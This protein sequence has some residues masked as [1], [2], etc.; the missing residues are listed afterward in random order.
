V[1][2]LV[3]HRFLA[4][5]IFFPKKK[6]ATKF[7]STTVNNI[8]T[9]VNNS[10]QQS[11]IVNKRQQQTTTDNNRQQQTTTD[12]NRQ[13]QTTTDNNRQQQTHQSTMVKRS[14][15]ESLADCIGDRWTSSEPIVNAAVEGHSIY[16]RDITNKSRLP[17]FVTD[18]L[19]V[20]F[21]MSLG[22]N[23]D[24]SQV[25]EWTR[26]NM[27]LSVRGHNETEL[28]YGAAV[29]KY[30][31][32]TVLKYGETC[33]GKGVTEAEIKVM[34]RRCLAPKKEF[35]RD[36]KPPYS[37]RFK[38]HPKST[39]FWKVLGVNPDGTERVKKVGMRAVVKWSQVRVIG[40][41]AGIYVSPQSFGP[42]FSAESI[43]IYDPDERGGDEEEEEEEENGFA[44]G[45]CGNFTI[46]T[47]AEETE[48]GKGDEGE[49]DE[50]VAGTMTITSED[51]TQG[52]ED[53]H[54][55]KRARTHGNND[56]A[57]D[58]YSDDEQ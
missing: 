57:E 32:E 22:K 23:K 27:E 9:T 18:K 37:W 52:D 38:V 56:A 49:G 17:Q 54:I 42:N 6:P 39:K 1:R 53:G 44:F 48:A 51:G 24:V 46:T 30:V 41:F 26:W 7:L 2:W 40:K 19:P 33:F 8:S 35:K 13:Q 50:G 36:P 55:D 3:F 10:Q 21:L 34:Q 29:D 31:Y 25:N 5:Q 43:L 20:P 47:D 11:T 28:A 45:G 4:A 58:A 12:N 16:P 14:V 15:Q